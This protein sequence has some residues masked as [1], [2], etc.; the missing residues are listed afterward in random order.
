MSLEDWLTGSVMFLT[1][2]KECRPYRVAKCRTF[3]L[4]GV[5]VPAWDRIEL[6]GLDPGMAKRRV[7]SRKQLKKLE[8]VVGLWSA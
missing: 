7:L 3:R 2:G 8:A 5:A 4:L 6:M 1:E